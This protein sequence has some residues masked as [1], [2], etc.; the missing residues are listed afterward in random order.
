MLNRLGVE[1]A[2]QIAHT[3]TAHDWLVSLAVKNH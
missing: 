3:S 2:K 1:V